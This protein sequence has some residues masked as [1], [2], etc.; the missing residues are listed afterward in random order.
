VSYEE[1]RDLPS[2][3]AAAR[4]ELIELSELESGNLDQADPIERSRVERVLPAQ[5]Q[6]QEQQRSI[7]PV[8]GLEL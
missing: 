6:H 5:K 8:R 7:S 3:L 1:N 4:G 2:L